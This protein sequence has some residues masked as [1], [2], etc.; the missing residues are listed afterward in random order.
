M[1]ENT[2]FQISGM[3]IVIW[4]QWKTREKGLWG[5]RKLGVPEWMAK[6]SVAF[7]DHYQA[8][9][10]TAGLKHIRKEILLRRGLLSC[11]DYY[12]N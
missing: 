12:L 9:A 6:K 4:K 8:A 11:L 3:R 2:L 10:K 1:C 5:L 7:G